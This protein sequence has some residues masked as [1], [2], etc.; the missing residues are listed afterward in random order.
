MDA[1][2]E[3]KSAFKAACA[4]DSELVLAIDAYVASSSTDPLRFERQVRKM[5]SWPRSWANFSPL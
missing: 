2:S 5:P 4:S 3:R 1:A